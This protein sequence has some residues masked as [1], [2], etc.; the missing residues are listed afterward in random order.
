MKVVIIYRP[1]SE[2]ARSVDD[3][4]YEFSRIYPDIHLE[5][6]NVDGRDGSAMASLYDV[7][8][9]PAILALQGDGSVNSVW[10]GTVP[11]LD[12]VAAYSR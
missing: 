5:L 11:L 10:Q 9:Y 4:V 7:M 1:N 6:L 12:E 8:S 3:F 2:H